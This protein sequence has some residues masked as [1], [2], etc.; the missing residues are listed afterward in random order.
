MGIISKRY[1]N[2]EFKIQTKFEFKTKKKKNKIEKE[3]EEGSLTAARPARLRGPASPTT[4]AFHPARAHAAHELAQHAAHAHAPVRI[5][6]CRCLPG[7]TC[8]L[9][10]SSSS[11]PC[12]NRPRDRGPT[13]MAGAGQGVTP[14]AWPCSPL[15]RAHATSRHCWMRCTRLQSPLDL[16]PPFT[17]L[18]GRARL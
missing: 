18:H 14:G 6:C 4:P 8:Q 1:T 15:R 10:Y 13:A 17:E 9:S 16:H 5:A 11:R 12:L 3:K 7:P 2:L